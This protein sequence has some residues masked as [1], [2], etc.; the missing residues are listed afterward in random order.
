MWQNDCKDA[1]MYGILMNEVLHHQTFDYA[2]ALKTHMSM[3]E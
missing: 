3:L 1:G 2:Q